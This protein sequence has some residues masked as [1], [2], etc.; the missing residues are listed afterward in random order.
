MPTVLGCA[1]AL[2]FRPRSVDVVLLSQVL[3]HLDRPSAIALLRDAHRVARRG[4]VVADLRRSR[5]AA[6]LF[7]VGARLLRFDPDTIRDGIVSIGRGYTHN[8]LAALCADAGL[9]ATVARRPGFR[10]VAW[11]TV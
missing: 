3:H 1:G 9:P 10:I 6:G 5:V 7:H 8:E 2:P 11:W 4:V